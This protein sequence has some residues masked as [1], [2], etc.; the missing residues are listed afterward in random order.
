MVRAHDGKL[1]PLSPGKQP[2]GLLWSRKA[3][4]VYGATAA[5]IAGWKRL[6][7]LAEYPGLGIACG[8]VVGADIDIRDA[9]LVASVEALVR[10]RIGV[11]EAQV[12]ALA[13]LA[14]CAERVAGV[15]EIGE[16]FLG[17]GLPAADLI[18]ADRSRVRCVGEEHVV[19]GDVQITAG[20]K[21]QRRRC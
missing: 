17:S 11:P 8:N 10:A 12:P 5:I 14:R 13:E 1:I 16:A 15:H 19:D 6:R 9:E 2:H 18:A 20:P 3:T 4:A 7:D 21:Q